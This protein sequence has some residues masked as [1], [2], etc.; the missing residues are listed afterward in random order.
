MS[1]TRSL[2]QR[3]HER[4]RNLIP[5]LSCL[6]AALRRPDRDVPD[7]RW[8]ANGREYFHVYRTSG[9]Q[10]NAPLEGYEWPRDHPTATLA[11]NTLLSATVSDTLLPNGYSSSSSDVR[12][13]ARLNR[14]QSCHWS[15]K[16]VAQTL[17]DRSP[18]WAT[19]TSGL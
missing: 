9:P 6:C 8:D 3:L 5:A 19:D 2:Q 11:V 12:R 16:A 4:V 1:P 17:S 10:P 14:C 18:P 7:T 13:F 15:D